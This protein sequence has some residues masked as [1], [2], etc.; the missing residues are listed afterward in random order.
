[1]LHSISRKLGL[2][3][4]TALALFILIISSIWGLFQHQQKIQNEM[5]AL[6]EVQLSIDQLRSQLWVFLQYDDADSLEQVYIAQTNL[7]QRLSEAQPVI[8]EVVVLKKMNDNLSQLIVQ[9]RKLNQHAPV[10]SD[11]F[12]E[13]RHFLHS[14]YNMLIQSMTEELLYIQQNVTKSSTQLQKSTLISSA[15]KLTFFAALVAL[16][17]LFIFRR[18]HNGYIALKLEMLKVGRG[19]L[20]IRRVNSRLDMEF[21]SLLHFFDQMKESLQKI[22]ITR[23]QMQQE[24][25]CQNSS[26]NPTKR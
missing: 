26:T 21:Q 10:D 25:D 9:E 6:V 5:D 24:I 11:K 13:A 20:E 4:L 12:I 17:A 18:F 22:T 14:R 1:M 8:S 16:I 23:D 2:L 19:D 3:A 15:I 7:A